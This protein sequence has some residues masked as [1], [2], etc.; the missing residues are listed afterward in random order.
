MSNEAT[1]DTLAIEIEAN[2]MNSVD[3]VRK[4]S[5]ALTSLSKSITSVNS[6]GI[7]NVSNRINAMSGAFSNAGTSSNT[8]TSGAKKY[9]Q[10][11]PPLISHTNRASNSAKSLAYYFGKFYANMFLVIRG[12]KTFG[13]AI[14]G[15]MDYMEAFNFWDVSITSATAKTSEWQELG[16]ADAQAYAEAFKQGLVDLN[17]KMT[18]FKTDANTGDI[19]VSNIP[20]LGINITDLTTFQAEIVSITSSLGLCTKISSDTSKALSM[21]AA[22]MSSLKN[23]DLDTVMTNFQSGLIGQ[24]RALYKYGIDITNATL[25]TYAYKYGIEK[26]VSE[27]T[28][29]EKMQL[30]MLAILDQSKVAWG[31]LANTLNQ[32]ANQFRVLSNGVK[33]LAITIGKLLMPMVSST[34]PY[35]NAMVKALQTFFTWLAN[36]LGIKL[37]V[38]NTG[39]GTSDIFEDIEDS[40]DD[41][42]DA[43]NSLKKSLT[44]LG[45]DELNINNP[46]SGSGSSFDSSIG[47][48]V[49][50]SDEISNALAEYEKAWNEAYENVVDKSTAM[51]DAIVDAFKRKDYKGIGEYVSTGITNALNSI[52]WRDVYSVAKDFGRGFAQFLNGL[53]TPEE[54]GTIGKTFAAAL[55]TAIYEALAFGT[56]F[57]FE[58]LGLSIASGISSFFETTDTAALA[59]TIDVWVQGIWTT[60]KTAIG[61]VSWGDVWEDVK[62]IISNID[63]ETVE[64]MIGAFALKY[65]AGF[66]SELIIK[67]IAAK[68]GAEKL[69]DTASGLVIPITATLVISFIAIE[70]IDKIDKTAS[71]ALAKILGIYDKEL[72]EESWNELLVQKEEFDEKMKSNKFREEELESIKNWLKSVSDYWS[73]W[74]NRRKRGLE[75][76]KSHFSA[77]KVNIET[78]FVNLGESVKQSWNNMIES[79][80]QIWNKF[81]TWMNEK[82][83]WTIDPVVVAG[84]TLF[85]GTTISLGKIPTF[86]NGGVTSADIFAANENGVPELIGTIGRRTAIAS[87]TEVTGISDAVYTTGQEEIRLLKEQNALLT[88]LLEKDF[89]TYIGDREI[90]KANE[91]GQRA[92]GAMLITT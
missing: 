92:L 62:D 73:D 12:I 37:D 20:N 86:M 60:I 59:D 4:L 76:I 82:L 49:D 19:T 32:P 7:S 51:A 75:E 38:E 83:T 48:G 5:R 81:A 87:G 34:L 47:G 26:A 50:L 11:L 52:V 23:I 22:D 9:T 54:F 88:K 53:I 16:Y 3:G 79:I 90:A 40:A 43:V 27:M 64:I 29:A 18:G 70:Y 13:K 63:I 25:Q 57:D 21:L 8:A 65:G 17:Q 2:A 55:N 28:Q 41:A 56:E 78:T 6:A 35:L 46:D 74:W 71:E 30:R 89:S 44:Q 45:I 31:D 10:I 61:N 1:I 85:E 36:V 14:S 84:K 91:R 39:A 66:S 58:N 67:A 33:N 80:K 68:I 24:S 77:F 15:A 42:T 69:A 72:F